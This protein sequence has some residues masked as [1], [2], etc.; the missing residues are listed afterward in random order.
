MHICILYKTSLN[1]SQVGCFVE[2]EEHVNIRIIG[3]LFLYTV[4]STTDKQ[5][6]KGPRT[7][8]LCTYAYTCVCV[9]VA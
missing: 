1:I 7:V 3:F 9:C 4:V 6:I 5:S 2:G 8:W